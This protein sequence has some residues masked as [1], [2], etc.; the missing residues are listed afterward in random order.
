MPKGKPC[1]LMPS[2]RA[3]SI[4]VYMLPCMACFLLPRAR[5]PPAFPLQILRS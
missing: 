2:G 4:C 5:R 3:G 1:T